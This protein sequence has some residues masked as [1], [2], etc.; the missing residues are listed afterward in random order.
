MLQIFFSDE[1]V[2]IFA[3]IATHYFVVIVATTRCRI[4]S[5]SLPASLKANI[6]YL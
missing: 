1:A 4:Q 6:K 5:I 3:T 2:K